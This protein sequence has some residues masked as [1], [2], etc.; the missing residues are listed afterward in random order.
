MMAPIPASMFLKHSSGSLNVWSEWISLLDP[1][2]SG[3][4]K[5]IAFW[6]IPAFAPHAPQVIEGLG[7]WAMCLR[8]LINSPLPKPSTKFLLADKEI[9]K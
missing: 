5:H 7:V 1:T 9:N 4:R 3:L 2:G 6:A 8:Q